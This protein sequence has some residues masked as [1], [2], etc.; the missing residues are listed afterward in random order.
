MPLEASRCISSLLILRVLK[1][2]LS[3]CSPSP[4]RLNLHPL[5]RCSFTCPSPTARSACL[6][7]PLPGSDRSHLDCLWARA[8]LC[9]WAGSS[10]HVYCAHASC[11]PCDPCRLPSALRPH[12]VSLGHFQAQDCVLWLLTSHPEASQA[13]YPMRRIDEDVLPLL[14]NCGFDCRPG[15]FNIHDPE[16]SRPPHLQRR[17][18]LLAG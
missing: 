5:G 17:G 6:P 9:D 3:G 8:A 10:P 14:A 11:W 13:A 2:H 4:G 18:F 1:C 15:R 7:L 12:A 16:C